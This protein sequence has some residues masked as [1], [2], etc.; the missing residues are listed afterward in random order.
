MALVAFGTAFA[1]LRLPGVLLLNAHNEGIAG[2]IAIPLLVLTVLSWS[3]VFLASSL[4]KGSKL[5]EWIAG[6]NTV[7]LLACWI[8]SMWGFGSWLD[9]PWDKEFDFYTD[10]ERVNDLIFTL[11]QI[12]MIIIA[13]AEVLVSTFPSFARSG[14]SDEER[15]PQASVTQAS[16]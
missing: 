15:A 8:I 9:I 12:P 6:I 14:E 5:F 1:V 11:I 16:M 13:L 4:K 7:A 3:A 10:E 2:T